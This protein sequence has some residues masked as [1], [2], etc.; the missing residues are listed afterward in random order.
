VSCFFLVEG[1]L[2]GGLEEKSKR[3]KRLPLSVMVPLISVFVLTCAI[4]C[5]CVWSRK[6]AK[7]EG[8]G[9]TQCPPCTV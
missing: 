9:F 2:P 3:K 1:D 5:V 6:M 4:T 7:E 8:N